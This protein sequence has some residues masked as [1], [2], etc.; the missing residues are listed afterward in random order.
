MNAATIEPHHPGEVKPSQ[1]LLE[2]VVH[3]SNGLIKGEE[4][5]GTLI[6]SVIAKA[7]TGGS[8][9]TSSIRRSR[10]YSTVSRTPGH[11]R[12]ATS[13]G[14]RAKKSGRLSRSLSPVRRNVW[15]TP[16]SRLQREI[17]ELQALA[18]RLHCVDSS[19]RTV[20]AEEAAGPRNSIEDDS[21]CPSAMA[22]GNPM[23]STVAPEIVK[24]SIAIDGCNEDSIVV[25]PSEGEEVTACGPETQ[26]RRPVPCSSSQK[27]ERT[28]LQLALRST[29]CTKVCRLF[30]LQLV[31][32]ELMQPWTT[33]TPLTMN[34]TQRFRATTRPGA[35]TT[36]HSFPSLLSPSFVA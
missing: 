7:S 33:K 10:S 9:H 28:G 11:N 1:P 25:L 6:I 32:L 4:V 34:P 21:T 12:N 5:Q 20:F 16:L 2:G 26:S 15:T 27:A 29:I 19:N 18:K 35:A 24:K 14:N 23:N 30:R 3:Q 13:D 17:L 22:S 8:S 31:Q 36:F